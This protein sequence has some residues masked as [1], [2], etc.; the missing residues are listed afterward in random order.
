MCDLRERR[1]EDTMAEM[2]SPA[3]AIANQS[4]AKL[5]DQQ[6]TNTNPLGRAGQPDEGITRCTVVMRAPA[7]KRKT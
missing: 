7:L 6:S 2:R 1:N 3:L 4:E 5:R